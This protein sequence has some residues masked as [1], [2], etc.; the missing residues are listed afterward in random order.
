MTHIAVSV[1]AKK[2][3]VQNRPVLCSFF[4]F[5][6]TSCGLFREKGATPPVMPPT[7]FA[8]PSPEGRGSHRQTWH[9]AGFR[10]SSSPDI[11][12]PNIQFV[13]L[14]RAFDAQIAG[15]AVDN[16]IVFPYQL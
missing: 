11:G 6:P 1:E 7:V 14:F 13:P 9:T 3:P 2:A 15:I 12:L 10:F 5:C 4:Q 8:P 16:P